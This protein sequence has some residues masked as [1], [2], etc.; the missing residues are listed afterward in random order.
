[1][2]TYLLIPIQHCT[3]IFICTQLVGL[4]SLNYNYIDYRSMIGIRNTDLHYRNRC[5]CQANCH[6]GLFIASR[7][8]CFVDHFLIEII[9]INKQIK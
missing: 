4:E 7:R 1:M 2:L 9:I 6:R 8:D 5:H 3:C